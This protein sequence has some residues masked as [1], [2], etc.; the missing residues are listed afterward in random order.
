MTRITIPALL[1]LTACAGDDRGATDTDTTG[2]DTTSA[3]TTGADRLPLDGACG[4]EVIEPARLAVITTDF[5]SG[6]VSVAD[7]AARSVNL[8]VAA[9]TSDTVATWHDGHLYLVHR[10]G[11]N[12]LEVLDGATWQSLASVDV[13]APSTP[14]PN[15]QALAVGDDGRG[16]LTLF[17]APEVQIFDLNAATPQRIGAI[18]L[19]PMGDADGNP[20]AGV[21]IA[22]GSYLIVGIQRL[23]DY[24]PVD[25]SSLIVLDRSGQSIVDLDPIT[26]GPQGIELAGAW[27]RQLRPDPAD[28]S[29]HTLLVLTSGLERVHLPSASRTWAIPDTTLASV[30]I[31]GFDSLAFALDPGGRVAYL[32]AGDGDYPAVA[33]WRI[34][35][36]GAAPAVPEKIISGVAASE[37]L[38]ERIGDQ[39]WVGDTSAGR[40]GLRVWDLAGPAPV[41]LTAAPL[42]TGLPPYTFVPIP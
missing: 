40:A 34:G 14:E 2:A 1:L 21:A 5:V 32:A 4:G 20:E 10:F 37:K 27:P 26:P 11:H 12:R 13:T 38:L 28:P 31:T 18:D 22:C 25:A 23:V 36:D 35:L 41:E 8:D 15:P 29:G 33:I 24:A 17:G 42:S 39:L 19:S 7:L 3:D 16:Y 6:G 9:A 30:G